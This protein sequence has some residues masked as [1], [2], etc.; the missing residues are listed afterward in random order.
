MTALRDIMKTAKQTG[1]INGRASRLPFLAAL[2]AIRDMPISEQ[3][4]RKVA[5]DA[6]AADAT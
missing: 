2:L 1:Y 6:I 3:D 5:A 4:M